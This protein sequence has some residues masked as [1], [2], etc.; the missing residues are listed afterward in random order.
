MGSRRDVDRFDRWAE[1]YDR[2]WMQR[3]IFERV[4]LTS[5]ELAMA[6]LPK[7]R[8]ILDIGCGTGRL[9]ISAAVWF[10]EARLVGIDTAK[11]MVQQ[12]QAAAE[13]SSVRFQQATAEALPFP[14]GRFDLIFSTLTFHHWSDQ[15]RAVAE[16]ARVL[17]PGGR[18][19]LADFIATGF[20]R[21]VRKALRMKRFPERESLGIML[22]SVGLGI[23]S[24]R[25]VSGLHGQVPVVA[26]GSRA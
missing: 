17:A 1:S 2:H 6:E 19:L 7:P 12:A 25:A 11:R 21:Y 9:L 22:A 3:A 24:E 5:L 16:V 10:P 18:W 8:A 13:G 4:Q 15:A 23:V 20:M 14:D 26:I